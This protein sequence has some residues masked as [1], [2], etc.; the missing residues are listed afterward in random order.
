MTLLLLVIAIGVVSSPV[1]G[2]LPSERV[3]KGKNVT[4][5]L[6]GAEFGIL[7]EKFAYDPKVRLVDIQDEKPQSE[8]PK[9]MPKN[10][11][12]ISTARFVNTNSTPVQPAEPKK[13]LTR[14]WGTNSAPKPLLGKPLEKP[15]AARE[16][17]SFDL[18]SQI[19][20]I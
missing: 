3:I 5:Y 14:S 9:A 8:K 11:G 12:V 16:E 7:A 6:E 19:P 10:F 17:L 18:L 2:Q 13:I 15:S 4:I 20:L 1:F